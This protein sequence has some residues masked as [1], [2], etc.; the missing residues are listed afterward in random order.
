MAACKRHDAPR[1]VIRAMLVQVLQL[2]AQLLDGCRLA[3]L[4]WLLGERQQVV[5]EPGLHFNVHRVEEGSSK[6]NNH[7]GSTQYCQ[8][9]AQMCR[10]ANVTCRNLH[11][12]L[13]HTA[14]AG[15]VAG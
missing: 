12:N 7:C 1:H 15:S 13:E 9:T 8:V 4:G 6:N 10:A 3:S 14:G 5:Q 11:A 2:G